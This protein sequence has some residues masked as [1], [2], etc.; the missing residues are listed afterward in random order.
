MTK[1]RNESREIDGISY[2]LERKRITRVHLYIKPPDGS[3][4]VTAPLMFSQN[5]IDSFIRSKAEWIRK[6]VAKFGERPLQSRLALRYETG[7]ILYFWGRPYK[8]TVINEKGRSRGKIVVIPAPSI[9]VPDKDLEDFA[10]KSLSGLKKNWTLPDDGTDPGEV[11][12]T[13]PEGSTFSQRESIVRRQYKALLEKEAERILDFW[14]MKTGLKYSSWHSRFMKSRWGSLT[15]RDRKVCLN[16]RLAEKPAI[17]LIYVAL[18]EVAH[19]K[20]ANHGPGFKAIL[21]AN[22]P[23]WREAE[24]ILKK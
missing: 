16:T 1:S 24:K 20:E 22:M 17:C 14:S 7:E 4:L 8:L 9:D 19:V 15:V 21:T 18:H 11:I 2:V 23:S 6:H 13:M 5:E 3:V 12:L 10:E